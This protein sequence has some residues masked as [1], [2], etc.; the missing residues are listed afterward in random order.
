M[1]DSSEDWQ[2]RW[3]IWFGL[4]FSHINVKDWGYAGKGLAACTLKPSLANTET[5]KVIWMGKH[6][7]WHHNDHWH[8]MRSCLFI[9]CIFITRVSNLLLILMR[10]YRGDRWPTG[11]PVRLSA[12]YVSVVHHFKECDYLHSFK[13]QYHSRLRV[14]RSVCLAEL[15]MKTDKPGSARSEKTDLPTLLKLSYLDVSHLFNPHMTDNIKMSV[16]DFKRS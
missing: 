14:G 9:H 13:D 15:A 12:V 10:W 8:P 7:W 5:L 2:R 3:L 4:C 1:P 11:R 6:C 16:C